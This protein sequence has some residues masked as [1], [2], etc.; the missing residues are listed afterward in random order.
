MKLL[1]KLQPEG[2]VLY[3]AI[4]LETFIPGVKKNFLK[5]IHSHVFAQQTLT[6]PRGP[7]EWIGR[8][9]SAVKGP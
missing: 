4:A 3:E 6:A 2:G 9:L 5:N 8:V 1:A 7:L